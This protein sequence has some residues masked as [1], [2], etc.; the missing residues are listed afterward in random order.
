MTPF[1]PLTVENV[2]VTLAVELL[3]QPISRLDAAPFKGAGVYALYYTG[4]HPA[5]SS[6]VALDKSKGG[7]KYPV[8]IGSAVRENAKQGFNPRASTPLC[9][10]NLRHL[11]D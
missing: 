1:D 6:L 10:Y 8:Y 9:Q 5:Y 7:W 2:G 4:G 11:P 3:K